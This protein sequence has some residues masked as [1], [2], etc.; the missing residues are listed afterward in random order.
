MLDRFDT[1]CY[2]P[3]LP[4]NKMRG[5]FSAIWRTIGLSL[6]A[7]MFAPM[8]WVACPVTAS[9]VSQAHYYA[10]ATVTNVGPALPGASANFTLS[11]ADLIG[12]DYIWANFSNTALRQPDGTDAY[13]MPAFGNGTK[14]WVW[15]PAPAAA[16][17]GQ[18][19]LYVG[20]NGPMNG[21]IVY[22]PAAG[23]LTVAD[24][25]T[26][27]PGSNFSIEVKGYLNS[28][29]TNGFAISKA[30]ALSVSTDNGNVTASIFNLVTYSNIANATSV[31]NLG[32]LVST[33]NQLGVGGPYQ[34][35]IGWGWNNTP[36]MT[37]Y[38]VTFK[39]SRTGASPTGSVNFTIWNLVTNTSI[40]VIGNIAVSSLTAS[41]SS[42]NITLGTTPIYIPSG[43]NIAILVDYA[44]GDASNYVIPY[45]IASNT[46]ANIY[47]ITYLTSWTYTLNYDVVGNICYATNR[48][49]I[50]NSTPV[51]AG[52]QVSG[53]FTGTVTAANF[54]LSK[55]GA[56]T[57]TGYARVYNNATGA[58]I[59]TLGSIDVS[60]IT[61]A[62]TGAI[63]NFTTP[64]TVSVSAPINI[65]F[66]SANGTIANCILEHFGTATG[67]GGVPVYWDGV[68]RANATGDF[69]G[70]YVLSLATTVTAANVTTG[71]HTLIFSNNG[72][73]LGLFI[74]GI[75]QGAAA[76]VAVPNN[77]ADWVFG[78]NY[79]MPYIEYIKMSVGGVLKGYWYWEP[80]ATFADHSGSSGPVAVPT[81][82]TNATNV[83]VTISL[84][85]FT[86]VSQNIFTGSGVYTPPEMLNNQTIP[87]ES[88]AAYGEGGSVTF[89]GVELINDALEKGNIP[90][91][92]FW[93]PLAFVMAGILG[94]LTYGFTDS[95]LIEGIVSGAVLLFFS[96]SGGGVLPPIAAGIYVVPA[97]AIT[98]S[99]RQGTW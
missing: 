19:K 96:V 65:V 86:P 88:A 99:R 70:A 35:F 15:V 44:G 7:V 1:A 71:N 79:S 60:T 33:G 39:L 73:S 30:G 23:G 61:T 56:P 31:S 90:P 26:L 50:S 53:N 75:L 62:P 41:P 77:T 43:S 48:I 34:R 69:I 64:V 52:Q 94:M 93:F 12:Q 58:L 17:Q 59:G 49:P 20:G 85:S 46:T 32:D 10:V 80:A 27:E 29:V 16:S 81:F 25:S 47:K 63:Y 8:L 37:I 87:D 22:F 6:L 28:T 67:F 9:D 76:S 24:N 13:Y 57:G 11:S 91:E 98:F 40:G 82:I 83:N 89:P 74:D 38:N 14:W 36:S 68:W 4:E 55:L 18:Y 66:E 3:Q 92:L 45:E 54:T 95:L 42:S 2:G 78:T 21:S 84:G 72:T 51:M 97:L 5:R